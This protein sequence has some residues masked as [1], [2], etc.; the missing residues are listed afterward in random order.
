MIGY[1]STGRYLQGMEEGVMNTDEQELFSKLVILAAI[2]R[3][4]MRQIWGAGITTNRLKA[5]WIGGGR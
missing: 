3:S 5:L 4:N 2:L 1:L